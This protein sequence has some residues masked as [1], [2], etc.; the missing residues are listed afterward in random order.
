MAVIRI[1][2]LLSVVYFH[3]AW[4]AT[5]NGSRGEVEVRPQTSSFEVMELCI[6]GYRIAYDCALPVNIVQHVRI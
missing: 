3:W 6:P 2:F 1:D 5:E 4:Y